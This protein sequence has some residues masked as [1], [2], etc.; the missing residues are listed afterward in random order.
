MATAPARP[1]PVTS[2]SLSVHLTNAGT[3]LAAGRPVLLFDA[4]TR[5]GETDMVYLAE[6]VTHESLRALRT[7]AGGY[8][9][10]T[11]PDAVRTRLGLP[12]LTELYQ[13]SQARF[14]LLPALIPESFGY[15]RKS[16][17]GIS[18]NHRDTYTGIPDRDRARTAHA[19]GEFVRDASTLT[20]EALSARFL[21]EFK[22]PG[23]L[24]LLHPAPG[25]LQ[26]RRGH[27]ELAETLAR[28]NGLTPCLM[29]CEMLADDGGSLPLEQARRVAQQR[30]WV[31]VEG[32]EIVEA[33][34]SWSA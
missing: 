26:E 24:P 31:F 15:D 5:E 30:G 17:F 28:M 16:P 11:F 19:L 4:P 3:E 6:T 9:C 12:N 8:I 32:R 1:R 27:T 29:L 20:D 2:P 33:G 34:P 25:L 21:A 14:P 7:E 18:V 10:I 22:T 13:S 23:H